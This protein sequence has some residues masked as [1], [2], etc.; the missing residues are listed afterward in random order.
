MDDIDEILACYSG[1][2]HH[3]GTGE[4][5][6]LQFKSVGDHPVERKKNYRK[7]NEQNNDPRRE[8]DEVA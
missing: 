5:F 3:W 8:A 6:L 1:G 2:K 4:I 7:E